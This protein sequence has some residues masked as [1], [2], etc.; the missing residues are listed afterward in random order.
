MRTSGEQVIWYIH[1]PQDG[2]R[3]G[4]IKALSGGHQ[5]EMEK[6][7]RKVVRSEEEGSSDLEGNTGC[8]PSREVSE[9]V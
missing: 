2:S 7:R 6:A 9:S 8:E 1:R 3:L 4:G 5:A